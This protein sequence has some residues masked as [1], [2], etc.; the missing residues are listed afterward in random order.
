[1]SAAWTYN[2]LMLLADGAALAVVRVRRSWVLAITG[3]AAVELFGAYLAF[4]VG[5]GSFKTAALLGWGVFVHGTLLA[6]VSAAWVRPRSRRAAIFLNAVAVLIPLVALDVF[7]VEPH[8]LEVT[9]YRLRAA[10]ERPLRIAVLADFQTDHFRG[11]ER[12]VLDRTMALR[13]DLVLLPGD[14]VQLPDPAHR[15]AVQ[16][17]LNAY[18]R[19]IGFAAPLGVYAV[20]GNSDHPEDWRRPFEGLGATTFHE[21]GSVVLPELVVTGLSMSDSFDPALR[22][23][24]ADRFHVVFGHS[25]D[26]ALG[27]VE[28]DLLVAGHVHGGQVRL[29]WLGPLVTFSQIPRAW[30]DT[31]TEI[32]GGRTLVVSRGIGMERGAAPRM[33]FL[34]RPQLVV[35]EVEPRDARRARR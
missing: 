14:Y 5:R 32:G 21:T 22:V 28:A 9:T 16:D 13:P 25:P 24:A 7:V 31:R 20:A 27:E 12:R 2:L 6:A 1:M 17:E 8:W 29:P 30:A 18:L 34:C 19:R 15:H 10:V 23:A 35:L 33:R 11:Y 3:A 4:V 26:F